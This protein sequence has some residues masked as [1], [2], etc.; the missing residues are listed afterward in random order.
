MSVL[1]RDDWRPIETAPK[2]GT[3]VRLFCPAPSLNSK[4]FEAI[5]RYLDAGAWVGHPENHGL[6]SPSHW[7][8]LANEGDT[9]ANR[10]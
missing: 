1:V 5:G 3:V 7:M 8:P 6:M 10:S 9:D 4:P 2:D